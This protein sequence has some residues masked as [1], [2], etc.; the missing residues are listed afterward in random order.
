MPGY[1]SLRSAITVE[2][3]RGAATVSG[4]TDEPLRAT[5]VPPPCHNLYS[6]IN[7]SHLQDRNGFVRLPLIEVD[8]IER[9]FPEWLA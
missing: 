2:C 1:G 7:P 6:N 3:T 8:R 9:R 5:F 4:V